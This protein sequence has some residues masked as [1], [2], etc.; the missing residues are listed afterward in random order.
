MGRK[1]RCVTCGQVGHVSS[2]C[3]SPAAKHRSLK[4]A[5]K[6]KKPEKKPEPPDDD[7]DYSDWFYPGGHLFLSKHMQ[8]FLS[9]PTPGKPGTR[10]G[11][12]RAEGTPDY[13]RDEYRGYDARSVAID[14]RNG[15]TVFDMGWHECK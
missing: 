1:D 9:N 12:R 8:R 4:P 10:K 7:I 2:S 3:T 13:R 14:G 5:P 11:E 6:K 15:D